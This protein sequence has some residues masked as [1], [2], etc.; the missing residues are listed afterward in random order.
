MFF[1]RASLVALALGAISAQ[2]TY[3]VPLSAANLTQCSIVTL[4]FKG[5]APFIVSVFPG[6]D[7]DSTTETPY[8]DIQHVNTTSVTWKVNQASGKSV[9]F[10]VEDANGNYDYS[11]DYPIT[12]S[13]D[14]SCVG[15]SPSFNTGASP[16]TQG[17][18][19]NVGGGGDET[20]T[21]A[22]ST[23]TTGNA[24]L[25]GGIGGAVTNFAPRIEMAALVVVGSSL[26]ALF[27]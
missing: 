14:A 18:P 22:P 25:S 5:Q 21:T 19:N 2:A 12:A 15:V 17:S 13:S 16:T 3:F 7:D 24:G 11:D 8:A 23:S 20:T 26:A 1:S 4:N 27:L 6:C 10:E 9:M